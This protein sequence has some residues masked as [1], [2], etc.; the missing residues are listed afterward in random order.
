MADKQLVYDVS[1][2]QRDLWN[3]HK[4]TD[5]SAARAES[6]GAGKYEAFPDFSAEVFHRMYAENEKRMDEPAVGADVFVGLHDRISELPEVQDLKKRCIGEERWAGIG[7]ASILDTLMEAVEH[8]GGKLEDM[9]GDEDVREAL[10][11]MMQSAQSDEE[12]EALRE[13]LKENAGD[14]QKKND[15]VQDAARMMDDTDVRNAVRAAAKKA[16]ERIDEEQQMMDSFGVDAGTGAHS[17]RA[18]RRNLHKK[19]ST[20]VSANERLKRIAELA[21]R[22][23][24]IAMAQ[25][26]QK[27]KSGT[28]EIAGIELGADLRKVLPAQFLFADEEVEGIFAARMY[29]RSLVQVEMSK[30]PKKEQGPIIVLQDSSGSMVNNNADAWAA[31]VSLSF[32]EIAHKQK[33]PFA[34]IH[35]GAAVLRIDMFNSWS[36]FDHGKLLDAVAYF[37]SDGG[38]NFMDPLDVAVTTIEETGAFQDADIIMLTDGRANV[39][40]EFL[41]RWEKSKAKLGFKC[42][43]ILIGSSTNFDTNRK[44]SDDVVHLDRVLQDD[45]A[46]H[47]FFKE[48]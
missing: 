47:K 42:Y 18:S 11:Q 15:A 19:L 1:A 37:A 30:Q 43:S 10:E 17:G 33:R 3:Y 41:G 14:L 23:R 4:M 38:T 39:T 21:G 13:I 24:R 48:V 22:L 26:R 8:P 34:I 7:A 6:D 46:M 40:D 20:L 35:F 25:Q 12:R 29:E 9:R 28:D 36:E 45:A 44:F 16:Q 32:L 31:A 27:P 5:G 2:F